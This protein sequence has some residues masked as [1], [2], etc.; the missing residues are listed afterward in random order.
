MLIYGIENY[1]QNCQV[2]QETDC[3]DSELF[4]SRTKMLA[5]VF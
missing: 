2:N 4:S 3:S 1:S 5:M